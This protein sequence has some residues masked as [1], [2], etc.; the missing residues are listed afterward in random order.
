MNKRCGLLSVTKRNGLKIQWG[1]VT[2][3]QGSYYWRTNN[4]PLSYSNKN[5]FIFL[6]GVF[7]NSNNATPIVNSD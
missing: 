7:R 4:L 6:Q 5:Y 2:D 1:V 3:T